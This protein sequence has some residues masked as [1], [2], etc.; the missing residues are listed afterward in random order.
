MNGTY[1]DHQLHAVLVVCQKC[2]KSYYM[3]TVHPVCLK[4]R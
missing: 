1:D 2:G 4:C 3:T